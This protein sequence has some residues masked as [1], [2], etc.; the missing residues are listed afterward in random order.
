MSPP[1]HADRRASAIARDLH[2]SEAMVGSLLASYALVA[3]VATMPLVRWT[4]TGRGGAPCLDAG[5]PV[6]VAIDLGAGPDV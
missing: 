1:N 4:A 6:G 3:A 2:V 5:L